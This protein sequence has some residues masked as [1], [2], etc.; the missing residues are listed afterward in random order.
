MNR[1]ACFLFILRSIAPAQQDTIHLVKTNRQLLQLQQLTV[2]RHSD[3]LRRHSLAKQVAALPGDSN[4]K[5]IDLEKQLRALRQRDSVTLA[6]QREK[7]D[8][9]RRFLKGFP[10]VP[11]RD[12]LFRIYARQGSFTAK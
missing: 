8:S 3:S 10:V 2:Q 11:F 12:T 4:L 1:L 6:Q 7:V 5:K 9:L